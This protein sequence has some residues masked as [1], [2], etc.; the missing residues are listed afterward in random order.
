MVYKPS[1]GV[2]RRDIPYRVIVNQADP[3]FERAKHAQPEYIFGGRAF[4]ADPTRRGAY[5]RLGNTYP[6]GASQGAPDP[7][8]TAAL[9]PT[10]GNDVPGLYQSVATPGW[11]S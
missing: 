3:D 5:N 2:S 1:N 10:V 6:I 8:V 4:F 11:D 7:A 9:A